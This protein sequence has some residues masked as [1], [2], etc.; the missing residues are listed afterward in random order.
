VIA[1]LAR[2]FAVWTASHDN[3]WTTGATEN[4][5]GTFSAWATSEPA[6]AI[7]PDYIEDGPE[8]AMRAAEYALEQKTGH[9]QCSRACSGWQMH[10]Q[11]EPERN[12]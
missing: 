9:A 3:G 1:E 2:Q 10:M 7:R 6:G 5:D 8:N 11:P 4:P 12:P